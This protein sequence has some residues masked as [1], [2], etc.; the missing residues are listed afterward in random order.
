MI[1]VYQSFRESFYNKITNNY[2]ISTTLYVTKDKKT[3]FLYHDNDEIKL[4][5]SSSNLK[6]KIK[7]SIYDDTL[8]NFTPYGI[9]IDTSGSFEIFFVDSNFNYYKKEL[10][11]DGSYSN[12]NCMYLNMF[13]S[14]IKGKYAVYIKINDK[15]YN[16]NLVFNIV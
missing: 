3:E 10:I 5:K 2:Q 15:Y 16:P 13:V 14:R 9:I 6:K 12:N 8:I 1:P 11:L 4:H 7:K